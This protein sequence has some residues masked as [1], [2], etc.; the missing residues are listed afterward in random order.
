MGFS[1]GATMTNTEKSTGK[2]KKS[3]GSAGQ[4]E[5]EAPKTRGPGNE[6]Q[7][8]GATEGRSET[9]PETS[10]R[11]TK[12]KGTGRPKGEALTGRAVMRK[13]YKNVS[14]KLNTQND[15]SNAIDD[16]VKLI[17][18]EKD[19]GDDTKGVKEIK[20]RWE[21]EKGKSSSEK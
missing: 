18:M 1:H 11:E 14:N 21:Q 4:Q 17:K 19:W 10:D 16:L 3:R 13:A 8:H 2:Q 20:V 9:A 6:G 7:T 5:K 15:S 12:S